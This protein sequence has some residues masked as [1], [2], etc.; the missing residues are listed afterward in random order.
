MSDERSRNGRQVPV[1]G[2][3]TVEAPTDTPLGVEQRYTTRQAATLTGCHIET[4]RRA[5][6]LW[7]QDPSDPRGL[8][9]S[10]RGGTGEWLI[11][12][13]DLEAWA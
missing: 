11:T 10:R 4:V 9:A 2:P 5:I 1:S 3:A 12:G 6:K 13:S 8:R 7:T